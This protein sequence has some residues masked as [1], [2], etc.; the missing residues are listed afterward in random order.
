MAALEKLKAQASGCRIDE[1]GRHNAV[2]LDKNRNKETSI[3]IY[4][5]WH[6]Y[7]SAQT[8]MKK[9]GSVLTN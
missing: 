6:I 3:I 5:L 9:I 8:A 4:P 7:K 1:H 2:H